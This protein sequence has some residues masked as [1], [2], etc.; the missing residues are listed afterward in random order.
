MATSL[1]RFIYSSVMWLQTNC[2]CIGPV[3]HDNN[4]TANHL[5]HRQLPD[6]PRSLDFSISLL[7]IAPLLSALRQIISLTLRNSLRLV[8]VKPHQPVKSANQSVSHPAA[9]TQT[10]QTSP[11]GGSGVLF[12]EAPPPLPLKAPCATAPQ[13]TLSCASG[14]SAPSHSRRATPRQPPLRSC[15]RPPSSTEPYFWL[16]EIQTT[17]K[18]S[19]E[20]PA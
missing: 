15:H 16:I 1:P 12:A 4:R 3:H 14:P 11:G 8:S 5:I 17:R 19:K 20:S 7:Q 10:T 13:H 2:L 6:P 18:K 9:R